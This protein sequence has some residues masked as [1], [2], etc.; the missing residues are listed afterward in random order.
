MKVAPE[1]VEDTGPVKRGI[2]DSEHFFSRLVRDIEKDDHS[3]L[4]WLNRQATYYKRRYCR[5]FRNTSWPWP[6][7]PDIVMPTIDMTIDRL[8]STFARI[9]FTRPVVTFE[10][11]GT[12]NFENARNSELFFN[13]LLSEGMDGFKRQ[14]IIGLDSILQFGFAVFKVYWHFET[15]NSTRVL[16]REDLPKEFLQL[17][18]GQD[19]QLAND[20]YHQTGKITLADSD[21][22]R[23]IDENLDQFKELIARKFGLDTSEPL[24][25]DAQKKLIAFF[26]DGRETVRYKTREIQYN[27]PR[28]V[29]L[30][31][32]DFIVPFYTRGIQSA[33]R[34]VQ[35]LHL[36]ESTIRSRAR[37]HGWSASAIDNI[38]KK[39]GDGAKKNYAE[40]KRIAIDYDR[41]Q[42]E[43]VVSTET[44]D[45]IE[46]WE[47]YFLH[48]IDGDGVDE[49]VTTILEP[50]TGT[51]LREVRELPYEHGKWPFVKIDFELNDDR[52]YSSRGVPEKIDDLDIEITTR[53]RNKL[54]NLELMVPTFTYRY[55]SE[56]NPDNVHFTPGEF[57]PVLNH[58]DLAPIPIP[59][60]TIQDEREENIL[61]TWN[62]RYLGGLDTGLADQQN[63]SEARTATEITA[64]QRSA[65][66]TLSF[67][68]EILQLG[69]KEIYGMI[70]DLWNQ[71]GPEEVWIKVTENAP[72]KRMTKEDI[73]GDF[74]IIPVGT[75]STTDPEAER[76]RALFRLQTL[77]QISATVPP[78]QLVEWEINVGEALIRYLQRDNIMDAQ[79]IVRRRTDQEIQAITQQLMQKQALINKAQTNQPMSIPEALAASQEIQK[80]LPFG[81]RQR[82]AK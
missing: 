69:M 24:D 40:V 36:T 82:I 41:D 58:D 48:D 44:N 79:A 11:R 51:P 20:L 2:K 75:V 34:L 15:R 76:Q 50:S 66:E 5:E 64:I 54:I 46:L 7:A 4:E 38:L 17:V 55:G 32:Q 59:D 35:R 31:P 33:C 43:G 56:F 77:V 21:F 19:N 3:R 81:K 60:R 8:K 63:I 67:R 78:E 68:A 10:T 61:L 28:V 65:S 42:R 13:W 25:A 37:D 70:W 22:K 12:S 26:R 30:D 27:G 53:H 45:L 47:V 39:H 80:N 29:A 74:N 1:I 57:Y 49:R 16:N 18:P 6:D 52:F 72:Y 9:I 14:I 23:I 62:Q 73:R 71:W